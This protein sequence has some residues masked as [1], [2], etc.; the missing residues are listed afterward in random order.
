MSE[1]W[2]ILD[3]SFLAH[4]ANYAIGELEHDGHGTSVLFGL[5]RDMSIWKEM[6]STERFVFCFDTRR[7]KRQEI[8]QPYKQNRKPKDDETEEEKL[9]RQRFREQV[10]RLREED[11]YKLGFRNVLWEDGYEAD[12]V[13]ASVCFYSVPKGD[14]AIV[15]TSD[16]DLLQVIS[17]TV[18]VF[19]PGS[20][21]RKTYQW[22]VRQYGLSPCQW[23]DVKAMAGCSGD[24]VRGI[25][26]VGEKTAI[27]Y[28]TGTMNPNYKR[29][30]A[31]VD[32][33]KRW[34]RNL[35]LVQLPFK[36]CPRFELR[37]D[38]VTKERWNRMCERWGLKS[39]KLMY[40]GR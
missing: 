23:A 19:D 17:P 32:G 40:L 34:E 2:L 11:L 13:M 39:L 6:F 24:N 28:L 3:V 4:R 12:D 37:D 18:S 27:S 10:L 8:Y 20:G 25:E 1:T 15:I 35:S 38:R 26:G 14:Q 9:A 22:F 36:G 30:Q 31:I 7:S 16:A 21:R 33:S 5:M 29:Y